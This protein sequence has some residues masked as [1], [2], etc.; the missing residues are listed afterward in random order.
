MVLA[1]NTNIADT[2][3]SKSQKAR[4]VTETW[5]GENMYCPICGNPTIEHF[6]ANKPVA[7]FY[8]P[9]CNSEYELKS[10]ERKN[11]SF[12]RIIPNG[13]YDTLIERIT[14]LINPH[15][16]I[17]THYCKTVN[18]LIL[19][20]NF[21]FVP[22]VIIKR[23]PL[24]DNARRHGWVG[25][26]INIGLIPNFAKIPIIKNLEIIPKSKVLSQYFHLLN[27]Q[28]KSLS[29]RGWIMDTMKCIEKIPSDE[30]KL[31]DVYK[32]EGELKLKYPNNNYIKDKLRQQ[33]QILRDKG[34]IEF[35]SRGCYKKLAL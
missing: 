6:N 32:F 5:M 8:C 10:S 1:F 4:I 25:S 23:P 29:A 33:L 15:L 3:K 18:N 17:M 12:Q 9:H 19:I 11:E 34:I 22:D 31:E 28:T 2:Y 7:D 16:F 26:N 30:F 24:G 20:P 27:L 35:V 14:S 13:T 21:F